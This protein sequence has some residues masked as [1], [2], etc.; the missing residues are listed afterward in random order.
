MR[1]EARRVYDFQIIGGSSR[2][3]RLLYS[4]LASQ[5]RMSFFLSIGE[6][7]PHMPS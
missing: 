6:V 4:R 3:L 1:A 7:E 5:P 2:F